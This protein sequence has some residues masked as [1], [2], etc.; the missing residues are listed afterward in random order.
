MWLLSLEMGKEPVCKL[1]EKEGSRCKG[2]GA[3]GQDVAEHGAG[4]QPSGGEKREGSACWRKGLG[5]PVPRLGPVWAGAWGPPANGLFSLP[6]VHG[7]H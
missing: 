2:P 6:A 7:L 1:R 3:A 4:L 5:S